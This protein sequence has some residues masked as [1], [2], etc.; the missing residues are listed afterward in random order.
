M[1]RLEPEKSHP[2][3][4]ALYGSQEKSSDELNINEKAVQDWVN[5]ALN[6]DVITKLLVEFS[7]TQ[8]IDSAKDGKTEE[9]FRNA[10]GLP[11]DD[12][13]SIILSFVSNDKDK[14]SEQEKELEKL[15][16]RLDKLESF[17]SMCVLL[18]KAYMNRIDML[19]KD[20]L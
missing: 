2:Y 14:K 12:E 8:A 16:N 15:N 20:D 10:V 5:V 4:R 1:H 19:S 17:E 7:L 9:W 13:V 6:I 18:R 3:H 11:G